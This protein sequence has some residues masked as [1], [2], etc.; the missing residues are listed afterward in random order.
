M[1]SKVLIDYLAAL[2]STYLTSNQP[3]EESIIVNTINYFSPLG[4]LIV[5]GTI[6]STSTMFQDTGLSASLSGRSPYLFLT[7]LPIWHAWQQE[8]L[9]SRI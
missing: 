6:R 4:V 9:L 3:V 7:V 2:S 8:C 5:N 1:S